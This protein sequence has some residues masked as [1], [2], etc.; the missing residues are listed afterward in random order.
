MASALGLHFIGV[1]F[2]PRA[3]L[4]LMA[5]SGGKTEVKFVLRFY[6]FNIWLI[7]GTLKI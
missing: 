2:E 7:N 5:L 6:F 4:S 3:H 1:R